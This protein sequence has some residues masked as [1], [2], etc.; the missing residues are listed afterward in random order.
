MIVIIDYDMGNVGS[1]VNMLKKVKHKSIVSSDKEQIL[2]ADKLI[3][4]G[5]GSFDEGMRKLREKKLINVVK[6]AVLE[7]NIPILGICLGMQMLGRSSEEGV[8]EGLNL[9]PFDNYK[10][11][12]DEN[13]NLKVPHMGW[14]YIS[15]KNDSSPLVQDL[16]K[17]P[18]FYFVHSFYAV[19]DNEVDILISCKYGKHFTA[20]VNKNNIYGT[21]F[22]PE[23]SHKFGMK[24]L[25]NFARSC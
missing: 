6:E 17:E 25:D 22:H 24:I 2:K 10:F 16:P 7:R 19:C 18:R 3:L 13:N 1:I 11:K 21:Q 5:V 15:V 14:K 23:K 9:I 4:P 12:F 20:A 8:E